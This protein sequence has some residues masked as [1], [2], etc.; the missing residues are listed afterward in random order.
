M[1]KFVS[2]VVAAAATLLVVGAA[3]AQDMATAVKSGP[4]S[5]DWPIGDLLAYPAAKAVL[6]KDLPELSASP[7]LDMVKSMSLRTIAQFPQANL[8][9]SKLATIQSDLG[10]LPTPPADPA[11]PPAAAP[12]AP[13][14]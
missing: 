7:Q 13:G 11:A 10:A 14:S 6:D 1:R 4:P 8:S 12:A 2:A 3:A 5:I 9:D